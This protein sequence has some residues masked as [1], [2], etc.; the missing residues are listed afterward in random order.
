MQNLCFNHA[1]SRSQL[2]AV[3]DIAALQTASLF[4]L[5]NLLLLSNVCPEQIFAMKLNWHC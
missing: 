1:D 2:K 3:G 5:V 4:I